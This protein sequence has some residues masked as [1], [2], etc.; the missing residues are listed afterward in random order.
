MWLDNV[1]GYFLPRAGLD[2]FAARQALQQVRAYEGAKS[3]RRTSG[4]NTTGGSANAEISASAPKIRERSRDLAR[5]NPYAVS[6]FDKFVAHAIG[7]G[8][9]ARWSDD[10][11]NELWKRWMKV[12]SAEDGLDFNGLQELAARTIEES[13]EVIVRLRT[14]RP[15][16]GMEVPLQIQLLEPDHLDHLKTED[17]AGGGYII[18]GVEFN[19]IGKVVA[20]WLFDR[21]PGEVGRLFKSMQAK[22]VDAAD[23]LLVFRKKRPGQVRGM[24]RLAPVIMKL[25]DL[26][27]YED[28][29]IVRKKIEACFT[30]FVTTSD[31]SRALGQQTDDGKGGGPR[32]SRVAP[33]QIEYLKPGESVEF[34]HPTPSGDGEFSRRQLRAASAGAGSTY[35]MTTGDLS[36]VNYS[37]ARI[38]LIDFRALTEQWRWLMFVPLFLTPIADR[39]LLLAKLSGKIKA[40]AKITVEWFTPRWEYVDPVKDAKGELMLAAAGVYDLTDLQIGRGLDPKTQWAKIVATHNLAKAAGITLNYGGVPIA[41]SAAEPDQ[42]NNPA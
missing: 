31:A 20:Y 7:T 12:A 2:R 18:N 39:W 22:R 42:P 25:R 9:N 19:S 37:S 35:E 27:D 33:G 26:D 23:V 38:G 28:A 13:G 5:N 14:R 11:V 40:P 8:I 36:Q 1:I 24:P 3:G 30:A 10:G 21:H 41:E 29:E 15:E 34:G 32:K 4:W 17:L 6:I 16:D